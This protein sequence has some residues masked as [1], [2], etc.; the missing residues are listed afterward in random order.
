M[1]QRASPKADEPEDR[2]QKLVLLLGL[3][4]LTVLQRI[5]EL[6]YKITC[7]LVITLI[8]LFV[9]LSSKH[10]GSSETKC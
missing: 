1:S 7:H 3:C 2:T 6:W 5:L 9:L 8:T 4:F 10:C